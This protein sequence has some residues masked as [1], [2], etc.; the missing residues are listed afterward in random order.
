MRG[1]WDVDGND[2]VWGNQPESIVYSDFFCI[3][4]FCIFFELL[5]KFTD[6][7]MSCF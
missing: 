2:W 1:K 6:I 5:D 4:V 7:F 3:E